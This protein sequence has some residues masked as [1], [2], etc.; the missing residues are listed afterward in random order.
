MQFMGI[1]FITQ[2]TKFCHTDKKTFFLNNNLIITSVLCIW[3]KLVI[4]SLL[5]RQRRE[6]VNE[7]LTKKESEV[8]NQDIYIFLCLSLLSLFMFSKLP[9]C[10]SYF[11]SYICHS[12]QFSCLFPFIL[13]SVPFSHHVHSASHQ[14]PPL[15]LSP[16]THNL[17]PAQK[18]KSL[19]ATKPMD[20][21]TAS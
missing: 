13:L 11:C 2:S 1:H 15:S 10:S 14:H 3:V 5:Q 21:V 4:A 9:H 8:R 19:L 6:R 16:L 12:L 17:L 7:R 18:N 20:Q